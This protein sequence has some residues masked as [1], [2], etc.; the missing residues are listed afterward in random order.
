MRGAG[1]EGACL[2]NGPGSEWPRSLMPKSQE[3]IIV[4][5]GFLSCAWV[6]AADL[7]ASKMLMLVY[8]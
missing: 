2:K 4:L 5:Q 3:Y 1:A 6:F 8:L 7:W